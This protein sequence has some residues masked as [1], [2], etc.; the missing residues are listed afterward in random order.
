MDQSFDYEMICCKR[1]RNWMSPVQRARIVTNQR[2]DQTGAIARQRSAILRSTPVT[3]R[4]SLESHPDQ[5]A[6]RLAQR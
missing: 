5:P 2:R 3:K 4:A 1:Y 6:T